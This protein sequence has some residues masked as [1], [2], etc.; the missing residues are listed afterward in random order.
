MFR[1]LAVGAATILLCFTPGLAHADLPVSDRCQDVSFPVAQGTIAGTLCLPDGPTDAVMVLMSGSNY[2]HVYWDFPYQQ[3]TYNFRRAMNKAG[4]ATLVADRLGNGASSRPPSLTLTATGTADALHVIVQ[5]LR[6][7]L[8]GHAP[9]TE[10]VTEGH[11][12]TSSTS[13]L[14]AIN[15]HDVDGVILTGYSHTLSIPDMLG[16][17]AT[18]H[19]AVDEP[20]F[21]GLGIDSGYL[22]ARPGT[23]AANFYG[24]DPDPQ[25]V[26]LDEAT[27]ETFSLSEYPDGLLTTLPGQ[28]SLLDMPVLL[29]DGGRDRLSCGSGFRICADSAT[30]QAS[31][32]RY[33]SPAARLRA[34]VLPGSGHAI[35]L[36][37]NTRDHQAVVIDWM[38]SVVG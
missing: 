9:F 18:Y 2:N 13:M 29:V 10:V 17:I 36:A 31:E 22:V 33:F 27:K 8:A 16:V 30:L 15:H 7:G 11:S 35:N 21:A 12:L 26:A 28:S 1:T 24:V 34:Y 3:D 19:S 25:V 38:R 20:E 32:S 4:Y 14:E 23:R 6:G 5:A 37:P